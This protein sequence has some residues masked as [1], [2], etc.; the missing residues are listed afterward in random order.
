MRPAR[1]LALSVRFI[2]GESNGSFARR[3][4]DANGIPDEEFWLMLGTCA[5]KNG[6]PSDPRYSDGY[7]NAPALER[8]A[9]M[10]G[11]SIAELQHA[12]PNL[13]PRRLLAAGDGPAWD[14][15]WDASGSYLVR[16]WRAVRPRQRHHP[17][18]PTSPR[19]RPGRSV[20]GTDA[21][22]TT[23]ANPAPAPS[24][25]PPSRRSSRRTGNGC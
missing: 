19:R 18:S 13:R 1:R 14:W 22:S 5:R 3:L 12:L 24:P 10:A 4:A 15:P 21:G 25:W 8:L 11:R 2:G 7:L 20:P 6:V 9:V 16:V 23:A 17:G